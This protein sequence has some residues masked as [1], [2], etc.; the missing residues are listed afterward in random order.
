[1]KFLRHPLPSDPGRVLPVFLLSAG[2]GSS[3]GYDSNKE[4]LDPKD[5]RF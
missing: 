1:M 3:S 5:P 2:A 4:N